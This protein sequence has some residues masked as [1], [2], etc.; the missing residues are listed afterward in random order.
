MFVAQSLEQLE[1]LIVATSNESK[2]MIANDG[3][4]NSKTSNK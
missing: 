1:M 2:H 3:E 4:D